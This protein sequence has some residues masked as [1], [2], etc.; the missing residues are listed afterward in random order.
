MATPNNLPYQVS[1]TPTI[2]EEEETGKK[3]G[4]E[5]SEKTMVAT[6]TETTASP[7][8]SFAQTNGHNPP[9]FPQPAIKKT[10]TND[11]I[12]ITIEPGSSASLDRTDSG[13]QHRFSVECCED[14]T[15]WPARRIMQKARLRDKRVR[16]GLKV[17]L[18]VIIVAG[19]I[20]IGLGIRK[21]VADSK[22]KD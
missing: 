21:A 11:Q 4:F 18:A 10:R 9:T 20:A 13:P 22:Q 2:V 17:L 5:P 1:R 3:G 15:M 7:R 8:T 14:S 16:I 19:A 12:F 6:V